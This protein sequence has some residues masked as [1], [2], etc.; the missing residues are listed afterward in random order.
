MNQAMEKRVSAAMRSLDPYPLGLD[1]RT[2]RDRA[3][4]TLGQILSSDPNDPTVANPGAGRRRAV[5]VAV[6][7]VAAGIAAMLIMTQGSPAGSPRT[8]VLAEPPRPLVYVAE[9][10]PIGAPESLSD[11]A[12]RVGALPPDPA[13][14]GPILRITLRSF[15]LA[16]VVGEDGVASTLEE[17]HDSRYIVDGVATVRGG[18]GSA[19]SPTWW[20]G[21]TLSDEVDE[22]RRQLQIAHPVENGVQSVLAA[23]TDLYR[24]AA[25]G[26]GVR[27]GI[28][29]VLAE[30][31]GLTVEGT[32][33]DRAG[34]TGVGYSIV[35]SG[36]GLPKQVTL[37]FDPYTGRLLDAESVLIESAGA[38]NV[39]IP[40]VLSYEIYAGYDYVDAIPAD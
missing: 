32:V 30:Q 3:S 26:P 38:L 18:R 4:S 8:T 31:P 39:P 40:S 6:P 17:H 27:A 15:H 23:I 19:S 9:S 36:G 37:I 20:G 1:G 29:R 25:P 33:T 11:F 2:D 10:E 7:L 24:E 14:D 12:D 5:W 16:T 22:L 21:V 35:H 28:L 34:R 13:P